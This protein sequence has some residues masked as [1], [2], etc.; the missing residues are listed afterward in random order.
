VVA[1]LTIYVGLVY[2]LVVLGGGVLLGQTGSPNLRLSILATAIVAIGFESVRAR[3]ERLATNALHIGASPYEVLSRFAGTAR[4]DDAREDLPSRMSKL[5][6]EGTGAAAAQVWLV[7]AGQQTLAASWPP[8]TDTEPAPPDL[9]RPHD[10]YASR[11][12]SLPVRDG[13]ELLGILSLHERDERPLT[14]VEERLFA[15]LAAQ[16]GLVLRTAR[17]RAE[18]SQRLVDLSARAEEL[19]A[20]RERGWRVES[21]V[22][23]CCIAAVRELQSPVS[24]ALAVQDDLLRLVEAGGSSPAL[25]VSHLRDRL[26]PLS[27]SLSWVRAVGRSVLTITVPIDVHDA[28]APALATDYGRA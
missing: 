3:L 4:A 21:A 20:S 27:G 14:P 7:V 15:G 8:S 22:Y 13:G 28:G 6:A 9:S 1:G 23:F 11:W 24:V 16:A 5:L 25:D 17:L 12:R 19:R 10:D 26:D 2:V 18:L